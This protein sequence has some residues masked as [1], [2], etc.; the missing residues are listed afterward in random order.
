MNQQPLE[1]VVVFSQV[2]SPHAPRVVAVSEGSLDQLATLPQQPSAFRPLQALPVLIDRLL[3]ILLAHPMTFPSLLLLG[4]IRAYSGGL[5]LL[6]RRA[7]VI[8]LIRH[9][10]FD[11]THIHL[12][13]LQRLDVG[14]SLD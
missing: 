6:Q 5:H 10:F 7:T 1:N 2:R 12:R 14:F 3:L 9:Y 11:S 13:L 8:S 4:N